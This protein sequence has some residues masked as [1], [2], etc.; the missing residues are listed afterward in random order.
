MK[1][2]YLQA[3]ENALASP[4]GYRLRFASEAAAQAFRRGLYR[5][6]QKDEAKAERTGLLGSEFDILTISIRGAELYFQHG[7]EVEELE[8]APPAPLSKPEPS[9]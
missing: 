9:P 6:R 1:M 7:W 5:A 4:G 2:T 3:L 8:W